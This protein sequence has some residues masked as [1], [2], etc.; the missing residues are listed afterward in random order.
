MPQIA[1]ATVLFDNSANVGAGY[2]VTANSGSGYGFYTVFPYW[3]GSGSLF[4]GGAYSGPHYSTTPALFR[5]R[6]LS[7]VSCSTPINMG[8]FNRDGNPR[9]HLGTGVANGE[10]CD[11]AI[12]PDPAPYGT[13]VAHGAYFCVSSGCN[14]SLG[15]IVLD[16]S[17]SN[18]GYTLDGS[19]TLSQPG[20]FA[21]QLC[22]GG[23]CSGGFTT[24]SSFYAQIKNASAGYL[25][26]RSGP[27]TSY[28]S[29][30]T[31]PNDWVLSVG[32]TT[33]GGLPITAN[34]Y[35]WYEVTDP[36]DGSTGWMVGS[37][38]SSTVYY[39]PYG[40]NQAALQATS[41]D[42]ITSSTTRASIILDAI[43]HYYT[44]TDT[45][46]SLYSS[47]DTSIY[48]GTANNNLS[49]LSSRGFPE[50]VIWG[51]AAQETGPFDFNNQIVSFDYGHGIMQLTFNAWFYEHYYAE[52]RATF[53]KRGD[54]S[55]VYLSLCN[56]INSADYVDCY[57]GAGTGNTSTK[58]YKNYQGNV[59]NPVY[60]Q[61]ANTRQSI[62]AN[63]KDG[64]RVLKDSYYKAC[65]NDPSSQTIGSTTYTCLDREI[66]VSTAQYNGTST[67]LGAVA[68]KL[69]NIDTY[70]P[71]NNANDL[72]SLIDKFYEASDHS[73]YVALNSP[74]D[75]SVTDEKGRKV[76]VVDGEIKNE[77]PFASY[78]PNTRSIKIFFPQGS[79]VY[80][81]TGTRAG[82]YSLTTTVTEDGRAT[83]YAARGIPMLPKA[84][85]TYSV[86]GSKSKP[87]LKLEVDRSGTGKVDRTITAETVLTGDQY[88]NEAT[89]EE[90]KA[91]QSD[92]DES[93][94]RIPETASEIYSPSNNFNSVSIQDSR[95]VPLESRYNYPHILFADH[96]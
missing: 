72:S 50:K 96:E 71:G 43:H 12:T 46:P 14:S 21:F 75:L 42:V 38:A 67:Y 59:A 77:I 11:Y 27:G 47:D 22:D 57:T 53:D 70:F 68:N 7:G 10:F 24:P 45:T 89:S 41:S 15:T 88:M 32:S 79:L 49:M 40:I 56:S 3:T 81:V 34:G 17:P 19:Q 82:K 87:S 60:K 9:G 94:S 54:G 85:H 95:P 2:D 69:E 73:V 84:V 74:G 92:P 30:K 25:N 91:L 62:Y 31:L 44:N 37:N 26:M 90:E 6:R 1:S 23:G 8:V 48:A 20:G 58:P 86:S 64:M 76:G 51:M 29:I 66:I 78:N 5:V 63:I 35:N 93:H 55:N 80:K 65:D 39:L 4:P 18:T 52:S 16:G 36:T 28:T 13:E 33:S 61:Y 83:Q